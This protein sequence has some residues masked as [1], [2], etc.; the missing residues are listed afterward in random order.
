MAVCLI[1]S[2]SLFVLQFYYRFSYRISFLFG[3]SQDDSNQ[4]RLFSITCDGIFVSFP[5]TDQTC[6]PCRQREKH[7][8]VCLLSVALFFRAIFL[9]FYWC[10]CRRRQ[11]PTELI[12]S[13]DLLLF[14]FDIK[15]FHLVYFYQYPLH[16]R[17]T[18]FTSIFSLF[19]TNIQ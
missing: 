11:F 19:H 2:Y 3:F 5:C 14:R 18:Q 10:F 17:L 8:L 7:A 12:F 16:S 13:L 1:V 4:L 9:G 15:K 6:L